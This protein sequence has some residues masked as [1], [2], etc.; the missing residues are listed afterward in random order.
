MSRVRRSL[1][2]P[3]STATAGILRLLPR[4]DSATHALRLLSRRFARSANCVGLSRARLS[5]G[6]SLIE[7]RK[8]D[9]LC[10]I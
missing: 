4:R 3:M 6:F 2:P 5:E 1:C 9:D 8:I 10:A 7:A